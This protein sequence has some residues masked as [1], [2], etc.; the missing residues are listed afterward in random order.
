M[1]QIFLELLN[2]A[3]ISSILIIA[4]MITRVCIKKAPK[5]ITC[6]LWGMVAIK[7]VLPF[8]IESMLS[9]IPSSKPIPVDIEYQSVPQIE[10]G[11]TAI[12]NVVNPVLESNF[13]SSDMASVNPMQ[14]VVSVASTVWIIGA[15]I[16]CLYLFTS[17]FLLRK[18]VAASQNIFENVYMCDDVSNPFILGIIRPRI[19]L[20]SGLEQETI[21]CVL[22]HEKAHLK[23]FDHIWKPLGFFILTVYWFNPLCWVAMFSCV[24]ILNL[25]VMRR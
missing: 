11:V 7:L 25:P 2:N 13:T 18:K 22:E 21:E 5:W 24:R 3:V 12:N 14:V 1:N 15:V 4:V 6:V 10:S 20:P 17:Y 23:R 8:S 19:Y 16:L 9:L